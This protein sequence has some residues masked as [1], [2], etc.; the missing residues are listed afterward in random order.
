MAW[1]I[2]ENCQPFNLADFPSFLYLI[3]IVFAFSKL[4]AS[5]MLSSSEA[6][7]VSMPSVAAASSSAQ[8]FFCSLPLHDLLLEECF[9]GRRRRATGSNTRSMNM[10]LF[11]IENIKFSVAELRGH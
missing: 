2:V 1:E 7:T 8:F 4:R 11:F 9:A 3:S 10:V 5:K 6:R